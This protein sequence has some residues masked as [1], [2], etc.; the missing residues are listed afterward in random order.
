MNDTSYLNLYTTRGQEG[1]YWRTKPISIFETLISLFIIM[2]AGYC[3]L[4]NILSASIKTTLPSIAANPELSAFHRF[5]EV[6]AIQFESDYVVYNP[7]VRFAQQ[8]QIIAAADEMDQLEPGKPKLLF[9]QI[10]TTDPEIEPEGVSLAEN[11]ELNAPGVQSAVVNKAREPSQASN[12]EI[13]VANRFASRLVS[14]GVRRYANPLVGIYLAERASFEANP[15][16]MVALRYANAQ[17]TISAGGI[18]VVIPQIILTRHY[19]DEFAYTPESAVKAANPELSVIHRYR[20]ARS[21]EALGARAYAN[22]LAEK[23]LARKG[24][25]ATNPELMVSQRHSTTPQAQSFAAFLEANPEIKAHY[26]FVAN[27]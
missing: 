6:S 1:S 11:P 13:N 8:H 16:L 3:A 21:L 12:P 2:V 25:L 14:V 7:E 9:A 19:A 22:P 18:E 27:P 4:D 15:E 10:Y 24:S 26:Q 23:Y 20:A 17:F 5:G